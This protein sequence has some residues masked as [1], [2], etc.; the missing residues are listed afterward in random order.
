MNGGSV[1]EPP[2]GLVHQQPRAQI[3]GWSLPHQV[4]TE[5]FSDKKAMRIAG[6]MIGRISCTAEASDEPFHRVI[7]ILRSSHTNTP[8]AIAPETSPT[9]R[10]VISIR[11][12]CT[13]E[14][15]STH[16]YRVDVFLPDHRG[17]CSWTN[18]Q[19]MNCDSL[20]V[21]FSAGSL[22]DGIR[23]QKSRH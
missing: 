12:Y 6:S 9:E 19:I 21:K 18:F 14:I 16:F 17:R 10:P 23:G 5:F 20:R 2:F 22:A 8:A 4:D 15:R 3:I 7:S 1:R 13:E 11:S